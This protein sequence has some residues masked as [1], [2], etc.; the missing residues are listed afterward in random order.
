[1]V[2]GP[3]PQAPGRGPGAG[4]RGPGPAPP[5]PGAL[6]RPGPPPDP[7][8]A[9]TMEVSHSRKHSFGSNIDGELAFP[10]QKAC[11]GRGLAVFSSAMN[12][13]AVGGNVEFRSSA[14]LPAFTC[15]ASSRIFDARAQLL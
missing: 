4:A 2:L 14:F 15:F 9:P 10:F 8:Q 7:A 12:P 1:M 11:R 6:G 3:G 13:D 5:R